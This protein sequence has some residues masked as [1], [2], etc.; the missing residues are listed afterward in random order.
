MRILS[1][2]ILLTALS[3]TVRQPVNTF[4]NPLDLNYR[5]SPDAP[6]RREAAD[7]SVIRFQ[8]KFFLFASKSGGY[9]WSDNMQEWHFIET[10]QIPAEEYAPTAVAIDDTLF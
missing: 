8:D 3:C 6:S 10:D 2:F 4:C 1:L 9:W 5:F 7:P